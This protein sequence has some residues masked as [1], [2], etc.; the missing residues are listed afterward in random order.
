MRV[1]L[2]MLCV[3]VSSSVVAQPAG[4]SNLEHMMGLRPVSAPRLE[5]MIAGNTVLNIAVNDDW[6]V[7]YGKDGTQRGTF[8]AD[9]DVGRWRVAWSTLGSELCSSWTKWRPTEKCFPVFLNRDGKLVGMDGT[10][11]SWVGAV[12]RGNSSKL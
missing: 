10:K 11:F 6:T 7:F 4:T 8:R 3:L 1:Y 2:T 9:N 12:A 5:R